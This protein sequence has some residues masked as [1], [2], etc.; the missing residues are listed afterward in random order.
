[1]KNKVLLNSSTGIAYRI[2]SLILGMVFRR[3]F[4][5]SMGQELSGLT[6]LYANVIDLL[7]ITLAGVGNSALYQLYQ[8]NA[9]SDE[10]KRKRIYYFATRFYVIVSVLIFVL[11]LVFSVRIDFLIKNNTYSINF[12]RTVFILQV[13]SQ[14]IPMIFSFYQLALRAYEEQ[15]INNIVNCAT[16]IV[17]YIAQI[18]IIILTHNY[19]W[20][21]FTI[22]LRYTIPSVFVYCF[23]KKRHYVEPYHGKFSISG[24]LETF[25][26]LK[27]TVVGQISNF[28]FLATDSIVISKAIGLVSVNLYSNYMIIVNALIAFFDEINAAV[29]SRVGN[30][31]AKDDTEKELF[32]CIKKNVICQHVLLSFA[33]FAFFLLV[34]NF[35]VIWL[36]KEC[37]LPI[38]TAALFFINYIVYEINM[39]LKTTA[40]A[41]GLFDKEKKTTA[42]GAGL[43]L[44]TSIVLVI[45]MGLNGVILGSI[46][47]NVI[48]LIYR[49][50]MMRGLMEHYFSSLRKTFWLVGI[51]YIVTTCVGLVLVPTLE[52]YGLMFSIAIKICLCILVPMI[53]NYLLFR[54]DNELREVIKGIVKR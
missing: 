40:Q 49:L 37:V 52:T 16:D 22:I 39:P 35:M 13:A 41:M 20:Y 19:F 26:D 48:M 29:Q 42:V 17:I 28:V 44:F 25:S 45:C 12:L 11:G 1:M 33:S 14:S 53:T 30:V 24:L 27:S 23:S 54:N 51:S 21:L 18:L 10:E 38:S 34:D 5:L 15:Y 6:G 31:L 3:I 8:C 2:V 7:K 4:I 36:G 43:N 46:I 47:G 50:N 32:H 9:N